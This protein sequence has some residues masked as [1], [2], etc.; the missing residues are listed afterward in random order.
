MRGKVYFRL[1]DGRM[2]E[3]ELLSDGYKRLV[4]IVLDVAIRCAL[5]N[6]V[7]YGV[8]S[9]AY[10]HGTV[11]TDE[12]DEHLH[13]SLQQRVLKVLQ[14]NFPQIQF[15]VTTHAPMVI[16]SVES[17]PENV[18]YRLWYDHD[19]LR[20]LHEEIHSYGLDAN[21][22]LEEQ[23]HVGSRDEEVQRIV[24]QANALLYKRLLDEAGQVIA[25]LETMTDPT[26]P[27]LVRLRS[28]WNRLKSR[29]DEISQKKMMN[30]QWL[31]MKRN[32]NMH[33]WTKRVLLILDY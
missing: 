21:L 24:D 11:V 3:A 33:K 9:Y 23:M 5:L 29:G 16:S 1:M 22:I 17:R 19:E 12:I 2:V 15:I 7:K 20:F 31:L 27:I 28:V 14:H 4:N 6:R 18:V 10:T 25:Q 8:D 30:L 26:Q 32:F 13:P